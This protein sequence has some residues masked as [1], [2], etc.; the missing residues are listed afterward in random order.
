[1]KSDKSK[2]K[3]VKRQR[4]SSVEIAE[5]AMGIMPKP[6][7][8][9]L[10]SHQSQQCC[11]PCGGGDQGAFFWF[12]A[13]DR[14]DVFK[15]THYKRW[16]KAC[17][18]DFMD[19][20][21][22]MDSMHD[23]FEIMW[24]GS[25]TEL[26]ESAEEIPRVARLFFRQTR[27]EQGAGPEFE[28]NTGASMPDHSEEEM[29]EARISD[30]PIAP[31][32]VDTFIQS[33]TEFEVDGQGVN[34]CGDYDR[35]SLYKRLI[36]IREK[37]FGPEHILV[38][39]SL[40]SL[41]GLYIENGHD[42]KAEPFCRRIIE[43]REDNRQPDDLDVYEMMRI[44]AMRYREQG[45]YEEAETLFMRVLA[46]KEKALGPDHFDVARTLGGLGILYK[47]QG[48]YE[49][50]LSFHQRALSIDEKVKGS[51]HLVIAH[52]LDCLVENYHALNR[53]EEA[54]ALESRAKSIRAAK[55]IA[56]IK[57]CR[58]HSASAYYRLDRKPKLATN[59]G[60]GPAPDITCSTRYSRRGHSR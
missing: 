53:N 10:Y 18:S 51:N 57:S 58:R 4:R 40:C 17:F 30:E 46:K 37:V 55:K 33:L 32:E 16:V 21:E 1:M 11:G 15:R 13:K 54:D 14:L 52:D 45:R 5:D 31:E 44:I 3:N 41:V 60:M 29:S 23:G 7:M 59:S 28:N 9:G 48:K 25:Y 26:L 42:D 49:K 8:W 35:E 27:K 50:A 6:G 39:K 22:D 19:E 43:Y 38:V 34:A 24:S 12:P 56:P 20:D 47:K 36:E 2:P